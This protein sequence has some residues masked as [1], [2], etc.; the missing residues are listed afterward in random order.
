M[1]LLFRSMTSRR[2][3]VTIT[4]FHWLMAWSHAIALEI[5]RWN[6]N[7]REISQ[8]SLSLWGRKRWKAAGMLW[9][10]NVIASE[11]WPTI[12]NS[13]VLSLLIVCCACWRHF[14]RIIFGFWII[15]RGWRLADKEITQHDPDFF[16]VP[17][18]LCITSASSIQWT[19]NFHFDESTKNESINLAPRG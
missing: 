19:V 10:T 14:H 4:Q 11:L 7:R 3:L 13:F 5:V 2:T 18:S 1:C 6:W 15:C 17:F 9:I 16:Y 12:I 8:V